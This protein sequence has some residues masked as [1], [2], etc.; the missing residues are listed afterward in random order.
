MSPDATNSDL[1]SGGLT[2][3]PVEDVMDGVLVV[4]KRAPAA[5]LLNWRISRFAAV[6]ADGGLG[7][8]FH[9]FMSALK[10]VP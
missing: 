1:F 3:V 2:Q 4:D 9:V 10:R 6:L 7:I 5:D 8:I